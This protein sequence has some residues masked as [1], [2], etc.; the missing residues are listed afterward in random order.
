MAVLTDAR[1]A[2]WQAI[3]NWPALANAFALKLKHD[4]EMS[5]MQDGEP[6]ISDFPCIAITPADVVPNWFTN[7]SQF[8][9]Y[10]LNIA[11][12]TP[13]WKIALAEDLVEKVVSAIYQ[14]SATP[15]GVPYIKAATG[16][17][18]ERIGPM[19]M[20]PARLRNTDDGEGT[21]AMRT[22]IALTLR[23]NRN[24]FTA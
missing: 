21:Q 2:V 10:T 7:Q 19:T 18:P 11:I 5:L 17:H 24:P 23:I 4:A 1:N 14:A 12:W 3:D 9:P 15:G 13:D 20:Q 6:S 16:Y 8:W 22:G